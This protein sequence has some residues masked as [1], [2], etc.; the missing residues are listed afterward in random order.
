M[1]TKPPQGYDLEPLGTDRDMRVDPDGSYDMSEPGPFTPYGDDYPEEWSPPFT[2]L[3]ELAAARGISE[4]QMLYAFVNMTVCIE[5]GFVDFVE[6]LERAH[7]MYSN[8][9]LDGEPLN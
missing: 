4:L 1:S 8:K 5:G 7:A 6:E 9:P 3:R 2:K